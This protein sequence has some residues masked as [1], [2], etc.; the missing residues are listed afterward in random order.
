MVAGDDFGGWLRGMIL[1][2]GCR[3]VVAGGDLGG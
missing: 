1:G 2:G 3:V